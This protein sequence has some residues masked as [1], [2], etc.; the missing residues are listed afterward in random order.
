MEDYPRPLLEFE[1][2]FTTEAACRA[3]LA[4]LR[5]PEGTTCPRCQERLP[6]PLSPTPASSSMSRVSTLA[7]TRGRGSWSH[8]HSP[9]VEIKLDTVQLQLTGF[10]LG[11]IQ[12]VV[13]D[14]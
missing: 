6:W 11:E 1:R 8:V 9:I 3:Y 10:H 13:D 5:W 4:A 7:S 14:R 12:N 2:R